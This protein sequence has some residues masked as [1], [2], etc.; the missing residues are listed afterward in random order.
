MLDNQNVTTKNN[1]NINDLNYFRKAI[2][3]IGEDL[4]SKS[5]FSILSYEELA[6]QR[7]YIY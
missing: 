3:D 2:E 5:N 4:V 1:T 7:C 6:L